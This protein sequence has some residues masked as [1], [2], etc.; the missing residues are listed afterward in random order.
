MFADYKDA[1]D[2]LIER[3]RDATIGRPDAE[4]APEDYYTQQI[5]Y[6]RQWAGMEAIRLKSWARVVC[7]EKLS[8][9]E[10]QS[11]NSI[12]SESEGWRLMGGKTRAECIANGS[13]RGCRIKPRHLGPGAARNRQD[14]VGSCFLGGAAL[15]RQDRISDCTFECSS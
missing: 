1:W 14:E 15:R 10:R 13:T 4:D 3:E 5:P 2:R 9:P 12:S 8:A 11:A 7:A 6:E